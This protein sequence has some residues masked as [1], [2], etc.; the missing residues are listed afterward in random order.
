MKQKNYKEAMIM[1]T[2]AIT[3]EPTLAEAYLS[4][5]TCLMQ[6][7][8]FNHKTIQ[9][10]DRVLMLR[11]ENHTAYYNRGL[12]KHKMA[13]RKIKLQGNAITENDKIALRDAMK[14]Y[15]CSIKIDRFFME[16]YTNRASIWGQLR[17]PRK[18][19][20]DLNKAV[21]CMDENSELHRLYKD[22]MVE[23]F[24]ESEAGSA[25]MFTHDEEAEEQTPK[26]TFSLWERKRRKRLVALRR[27]SVEGKNDLKF[28][29]QN[30]IK[31][32][33]KLGSTETAET[34]EKKL[35][36]LAVHEAST[37]ST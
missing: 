9:I 5:G 1:L 4:K 3:R 13:V 31:V 32:L 36:K 12:C 23:K 8:E 21:Q 16:A 15:T 20:A 26:T 22:L 10:F 6:M 25:D 11:P 19:R 35:E 2:E 28:L 29:L 30:R 33:H 18:A 24:G 37:K 7:G 34:D 17:D 14:D 27:K